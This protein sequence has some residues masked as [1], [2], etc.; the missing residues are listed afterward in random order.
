MHPAKARFMELQRQARM[1]RLR[2]TFG[3]PLAV[4]YVTPPRDC[5]IRTL[6]AMVAKIALDPTCH[7]Q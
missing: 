3:H 5:S 7:P 1:R 2:K 4:I 6:E